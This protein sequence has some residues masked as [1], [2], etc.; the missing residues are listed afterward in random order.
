V[1]QVLDMGAAGGS[2]MPLRMASALPREVPVGSEVRPA[3]A[4]SAGTSNARVPVV[5]TT[6]TPNVRDISPW[7]AS[8]GTKV[9]VS[10]WGRVFFCSFP[11]F[12]LYCFFLSVSISLD[13]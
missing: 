11:P 13:G 10:W 6:E 4:A 8:I 12:F 2:T 5:L 7:S 9:T 1:A 3:V